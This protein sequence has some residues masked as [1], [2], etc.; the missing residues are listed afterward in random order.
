MKI[1]QISNPEQLRDFNNEI[2]MTKLFGSLGITPKIISAYIG[3]YIGFMIIEKMDMTADRVAIEI[4]KRIKNPRQ[5]SKIKEI[6]ESKFA[7]VVN[8]LHDAGYVHGH[9]YS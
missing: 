4:K 5:L 1:V 6:L 3:E 9:L 7:D 8:K 2:E